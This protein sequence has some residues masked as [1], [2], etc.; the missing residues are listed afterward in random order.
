MQN[1]AGEGGHLPAGL[2]GWP[3]CRRQRRLSEAHIGKSFLALGSGDD[4]EMHSKH[5]HR[6]KQADKPGFVK[7]HPRTRGKSQKAK[8]SQDRRSYFQITH[9]T[10][11]EH[12]RLTQNS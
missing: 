10:R 4:V 5:R 11:S 7:L 8:V 12:P 6:K 2:Q 9:L 3:A 1:G